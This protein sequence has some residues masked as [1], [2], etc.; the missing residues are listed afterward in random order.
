MVLVWLILFK[1]ISTCIL[2]LFQLGFPGLPNSAVL[3]QE[4]R[5]VFPLLTL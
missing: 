2:E 5:Q 4:S 1:E 3:L